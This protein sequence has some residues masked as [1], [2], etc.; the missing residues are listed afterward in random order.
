MHQFW[1]VKQPRPKK[2][3]QRQVWA[4]G[5]RS[6]QRTGA[7]V[8]RKADIE[9]GHTGVIQALNRIHT[10]VDVIGLPH[11]I[12]ITGCRQHDRLAARALL[13]YLPS[14]GMVFADKAY[15]ASEIRVS[16]RGSWANTPLRKNRSDPICLSPYLLPPPKSRRAVLQPDQASPSHCCT[17]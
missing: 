12:M 13:E 1:I 17:L 11:H 10:V 4:L 2:Q 7:G 5:G 9:L 14:G 8:E 3:P 6:T 16:S 15:D